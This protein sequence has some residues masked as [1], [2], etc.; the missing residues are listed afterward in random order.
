MAHAGF[1]FVSHLGLN[2]NVK[3]TK[4]KHYSLEVRNMT[5]THT[6]DVTV[7]VHFFI[8][9]FNIRSVTHVAVCNRVESGSPSIVTPVSILRPEVGPVC[10]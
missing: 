7:W 9:N 8:E 6:N 10:R 3:K 2:R 5:R 1:E 4:T